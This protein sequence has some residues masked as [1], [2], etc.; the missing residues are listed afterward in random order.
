V[1]QESNDRQFSPA[2]NRHDHAQRRVEVLELLAR[3]AERDVVHSRA[4]V[5]LRDRDPQQSELRHTAQNPFAIE[6]MLAVVLADVRRHFAGAP[7]ANGT[8]EQF[9]FVRKSEINH[10]ERGIVSRAA[11][12]VHGSAPAQIERFGRVRAVGRHLQVVGAPEQRA[13][14]AGGRV[15][16]C[17]HDAG[18]LVIA[19]ADLQR[20]VRQLFKGPAIDVGDQ[21]AEAIDA[22]DLAIDAVALDNRPWDVEPV[23]GCRPSGRG[24]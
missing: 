2:V 20:T 4:A 6:V 11:G 7:L 3:D 24:R 12:D 15:G 14:L 21:V 1:P 9:V 22:K 10:D 8:L 16:V 5:L 17:R 18:D 13:D 19:D 23:D